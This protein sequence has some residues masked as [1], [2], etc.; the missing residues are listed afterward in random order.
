[1]RT[2]ASK[3]ERWVGLTTRPADPNAVTAEELNA[4]VRM[5]CDLLPDSR[6]SAAGSVT[7]SEGSLCEGTSNR[8]TEQQF[9]GT[10]TMFRM[11]DPDTGQPVEHDAFELVRDWGTGL[12]IATSKGVSFEEDFEDGQEYSLFELTTDNTQDPSDRGAYI[13]QTIPLFV[14]NGWLNKIVAAGGAG[15]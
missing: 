2:L 14:H 5:E 8:P 3:R 1:M 12:H 4:G 9:E 7:V 6:L 13:K 10:M 15:G 11:Y